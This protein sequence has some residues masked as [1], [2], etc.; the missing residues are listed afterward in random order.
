M[1]VSTH[2]YTHTHIHHTEKS[3]LPLS[4]TQQLPQQR[5][6]SESYC[7]ESVSLCPSSLTIIWGAG[8]YLKS[9]W[10]AWVP[11]VPTDVT[12]V[13]IS[14]KSLAAVP[15]LGC[16]IPQSQSTLLRSCREEAL[17]PSLVIFICR[18]GVLTHH[19]CSFSRF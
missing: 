12:K 11:D 3:A 19:H 5:L 14:V 9:G 1:R 18:T 13:S 8:R 7:I 10:K 17:A 15:F 6:H 16:S 4:H 2:M